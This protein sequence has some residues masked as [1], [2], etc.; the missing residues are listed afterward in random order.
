M[1]R[2]RAQL[3]PERAS[4]R[5]AVQGAH[6]PV[7]DALGRHALGHPPAVAPVRGP[8]RAV[9]RACR[10]TGVREPRRAQRGAAGA[11]GD[12][13]RRP[14]RV[15]GRWPM[16]AD[17]GVAAPAAPPR[18]A[19]GP[20]G[21]GRPDAV[22]QVQHGTLGARDAARRGPGARAPDGRC[23]RGQGVRRRG[24]GRADA[25]RHARG[26]EHGLGPGPRQ[27]RVPRRLERLR[28]RRA[29]CVLGHARHAAGLVRAV[30]LARHGH[31]GRD[32][33]GSGG[34]DG[35]RRRPRRQPGSRPVDRLVPHPQGPR[36]RQDRR[37]QP[38]H[39]VAHERARVLGRPPLVHGAVRGRVRRRRRACAR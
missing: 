27:P 39:R 17:L 30:W 3:P 26:E 8:V 31:R 13:R 22:P 38:W 34:R 37:P 36:L 10:A 7:A 35:P 32:G 24:R 9:R 25:R 20:R 21:D 14:V 16:G 5:L 15:P 1:H 11:R 2:P 23:R 28:D 18:R 4:G 29:R 6:G 33:L 19:A 12:R